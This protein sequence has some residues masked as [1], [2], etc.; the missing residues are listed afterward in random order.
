MLL[1]NF[2]CVSDGKNMIFA[3]KKGAKPYREAIESAFIEKDGF[4]VEVADK[5]IFYPSDQ[6]AFPL[7]VGIAA[8]HKAKGIGLWLGRIHT[9]RDTVLDMTN[10]NI[11]R[12]AI[13]SLIGS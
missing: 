9:S 12:A 3:L 10:V 1:L 8:F 5:G 11:L 7:G 2:D 6:A 4:K 13:I